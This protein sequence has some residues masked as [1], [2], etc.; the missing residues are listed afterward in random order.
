[1]LPFYQLE[2]RLEI[3]CLFKSFF[4]SFYTIFVL[5]FLINILNIRTTSVLWFYFKSQIQLRKLKK[6]KVYHIHP[7]Y[8][9]SFLISKDSFFYHFFLFGPLCLIP[10][11]T[12]ALFS[13]FK[14]ILFLPSSESI[15]SLSIVSGLTV[16]YFST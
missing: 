4:L 14:N 7:Y 10:L 16:F 13:S 11:V 6:K 1:M 5:I 8:Y 12:N 9:S 3:V 2:W 15:I